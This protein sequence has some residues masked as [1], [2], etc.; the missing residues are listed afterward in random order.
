MPNRKISY[1]SPQALLPGSIVSN[2]LSGNEPHRIEWSALAELIR[3]VAPGERLFLQ[4]RERLPTL[5]H[6]QLPL[7]C[8][9]YSDYYLT[10]TQ[11]P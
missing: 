10:K 2:A 7:G 6:H 4:L 3:S 1:P 8:K 11:Q 9:D 5:V